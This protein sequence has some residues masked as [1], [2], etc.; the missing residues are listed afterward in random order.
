MKNFPLIGVGITTM[1]KSGNTLDAGFP[2]ISFQNGDSKL[3]KYF[4]KLNG[5]M[6]ND[7]MQI[8]DPN[9]GYPMFLM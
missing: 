9:L 3:D 2:Y 6:E 8:D 7:L 1:T 4:E 5:L